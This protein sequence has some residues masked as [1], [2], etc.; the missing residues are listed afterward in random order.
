MVGKILLI[1]VIVIVSIVALFVILI[2][3]TNAAMKAKA[4]KKGKDTLISFY[5][6]LIDKNYSSAVNT[7]SNLIL[8]NETERKDW[9]KNIEIKYSDQEILNYQIGSYNFGSM[10]GRYIS[11]IF[12]SIIIRKNEKGTISTSS[13]TIRLIEEQNASGSVDMKIINCPDFTSEE[14]DR[15]E[16]NFFSLKPNRKMGI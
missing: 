12:Y 3:I 1:I 8:N 10:S 14:L 5:N 4:V 13:E 15:V 9:I 7:I 2:P 16:E 11:Q 6:S